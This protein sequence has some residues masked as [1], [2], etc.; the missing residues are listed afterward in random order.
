[1]FNALVFIFHFS[2][3]VGL[4]F[5]PYPDFHQKNAMQ[6]ELPETFLVFIFHFSTKAGLE[7]GTYRN[8]HEI[9]CAP[10]KNLILCWAFWKLKTVVS[11]YV[12]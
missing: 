9:F 8:F 5:V 11:L 12:I 1:M 4:E 3:K 2:T 7:C 6:T 10:F